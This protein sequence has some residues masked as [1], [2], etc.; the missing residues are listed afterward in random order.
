MRRMMQIALAHFVKFVQFVSK[1]ND[2]NFVY[3][4]IR[5]CKILMRASSLLNCQTI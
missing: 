1:M 2:K 3:P 5:V 4:V